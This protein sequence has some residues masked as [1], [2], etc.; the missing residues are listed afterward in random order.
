MSI[1]YEGAPATSSITVATSGREVG[2]DIIPDGEVA[3]IIN[4]DEVFYVQGTVEQLRDFITRAD[5]AL[6]RVEESQTKQGRHMQK[7]YQELAEAIASQ[8]EA[9]AEGNF[10][11]R[12]LWAQVVLLEN[13]IK[14][15]K[16]W[17]KE[18]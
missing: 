15:L 9:I 1:R 13:N 5:K 14:T 3:L 18:E 17:T 16:E 4:Y 12:S 6:R 7:Q 11:G 8:A 10:E 2:D